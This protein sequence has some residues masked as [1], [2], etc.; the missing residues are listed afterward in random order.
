MGARDRI[1]A[2]ESTFAIEMKE[3]SAILNQVDKYSLAILDE[4]GR[5]TSPNEGESIAWAVLK[6]L[7]NTC[8]VLFATHYHS[9]NSSF[10]ANPMVSLHHMPL[11][12]P[13][14]EADRFKLLSGTLFIYFY[15]SGL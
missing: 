3:T 2:G 7:C 15:L 11:I 14:N 12:N 8:R 1:A 9:L 6:S 4:L 13:E 10:E 5:G